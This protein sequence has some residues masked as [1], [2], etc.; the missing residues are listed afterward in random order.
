[1]RPGRAARRLG[2]RQ[3]GAALATDAVAGAPAA[4][5]RSIASRF[6]RHRSRELKGIVPTR[7]SSGPGYYPSATMR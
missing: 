7:G 2:R 3:G 6:S 1:M 4:I 5:Q